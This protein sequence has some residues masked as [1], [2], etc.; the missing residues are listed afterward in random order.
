MHI[1]MGKKKN[2]SKTFN[3]V[4][5]MMDHIKERHKNRTKLQKVL[6]F[7]KYRIIWDYIHPLH[8]SRIYW[9]T[10]NFVQKKLW[11]F[12][13][14]EIMDLDNEFCNWIIPKLKEYSSSEASFKKM[15][16]AF[17]LNL[18]DEIECARPLN[19]EKFLADTTRVYKEI[20]EGVYL[21]VKSFRLF[22]DLEDE[23]I[24]WLLPRL[25]RFLK[26]VHSYPS[27]HFDENGLFV[28]EENESLEN[29]Q[30]IIN[31]IITALEFIKF[32]ITSTTTIDNEPYL[33]YV[34]KEIN[35]GLN[36]F[37]MYFMNLWN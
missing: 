34:D 30:A 2:E 18:D 24:D 7:I 16:R 32:R 29:W 20:Y 37:T 15:I 23:V 11:G 3:S 14:Y 6:D 13:D 28:K 26:I 27:G 19:H 10:K 12:N 36:L 25:K 22:S 17:E 1:L 35:K 21:F 4:D 5:E 8:P 9:R 31:D 33:K